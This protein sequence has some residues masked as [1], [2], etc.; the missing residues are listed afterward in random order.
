MRTE[1][2]QDGE[3]TF[4]PRLKK[5]IGRLKRIAKR[6]NIAAAIIIY[7]PGFSEWTVVI[8]PCFSHVR[9]SN[10][11]GKLE[12]R[13]SMDRFASETDRREALEGTMTMILHFH[14][15]SRLLAG[16]FANMLRQVERDTKVK[17]P[18]LQKEEGQ[19]TTAEAKPIEKPKPTR[20]NFINTIVELLIQD[21][22]LEGKEFDVEKA[23]KQLQTYL[24][25]LAEKRGGTLQAIFGEL[26]TK[27]ST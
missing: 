7:E 4:S 1:L 27:L 11:P 2:P 21:P 19:E 8:D 25:D 9:F 13:D 17:P 22:D 18:D 20:E 6:K 12:I 23:R 5:I 26:E 15:M 16:N 24:T 3:P 14:N 10:T